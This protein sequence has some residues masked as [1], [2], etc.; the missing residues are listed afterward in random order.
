MLKIDMHFDVRKGVY[1]KL[2]I[3]NENNMTLLYIIV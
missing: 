1:N 3:S 2:T